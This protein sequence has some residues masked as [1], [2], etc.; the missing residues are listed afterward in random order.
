MYM[1]VALDVDGYI[2]TMYDPITHESLET[3]TAPS[4]IIAE[5]QRDRRWVSIRRQVV[6]VGGRLN[7]RHAD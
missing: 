1:P 5:A 6:I 3:E 7:A 2:G 4:S